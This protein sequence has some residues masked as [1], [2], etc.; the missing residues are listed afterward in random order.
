MKCYQIYFLLVWISR[1]LHFACPISK[2]SI[3]APKFG[4]FVKCGSRY[5]RK[6][7]TI[8]LIFNSK[9]WNTPDHLAL[10]FKFKLKK[11][12]PKLRPWECRKAKMQN[13]HHDVIKLELWKTTKKSLANICQIICKTIIKIVSFVLAAEITHTY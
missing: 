4:F 5:H 1:N 13:G 6:L 2:I 7:S 8:L 11:V 3:F 12:G 9:H 10:K